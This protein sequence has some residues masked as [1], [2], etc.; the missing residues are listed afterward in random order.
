VANELTRAINALSAKIDERAVSL[1]NQ[2]YYAR[3]DLTDDERLAFARLYNQL[4]LRIGRVPGK[5][6]V[7]FDTLTE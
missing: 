6:Y 1:N 3:V 4:Y 5:I 2:P 7:A